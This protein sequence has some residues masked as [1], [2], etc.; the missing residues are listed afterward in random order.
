V[1]VFINELTE[2]AQLGVELAIVH[3]VCMVVLD[4]IGA[5]IP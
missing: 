3:G 2:R 4:S 5:A 1:A